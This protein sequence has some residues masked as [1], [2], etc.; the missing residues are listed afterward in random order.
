MS[1]LHWEALRK[2]HVLDRK[3][4]IEKERQSKRKD[5][6]EQNRRELEE[7][8]KFKKNDPR[9]MHAGYDRRLHEMLPCGRGEYHNSQDPIRRKNFIDASREDYNAKVANRYTSIHYAQQW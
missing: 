7:Y 5:L 1:A 8:E 2:Q 4:F 6:A 3:H 9:G